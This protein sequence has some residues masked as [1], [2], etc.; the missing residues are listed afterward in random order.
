MVDRYRNYR[1]QKR[2]QPQRQKNR[3][4][5][6][7]VIILA[8]L[9]LGG[10]TVWGRLQHKPQ[11]TDS[12]SSQPEPKPIVNAEPIPATTW[13]ELNQR[14]SALIAAHAALDISVA[15]IDI[16]SNTKAS[17]GI[18]DNFAGASTTKI[19][20]AAAYLH[21]VETAQRSLDEQLDNAA[22]RTHLRRMINRSDNNSWATL[23]RAVGSSQLES[24]AH[25]QGITSYKFNQNLITANDE[26]LL[27]AKLYRGEILNQAH[28][29]L[30][31]SFMQNTNNEDMIPVVAP[32]E[33]ALYHKYGQLE[34]R[35]HDAA[36]VDYQNHP[37]VLVIYTKGGASDGSNYA[38]RIQL[39]QELARNVFE[40]IYQE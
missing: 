22:G 36:I 4:S 17:Y 28:K 5:I 26:A 34:D 7:V 8:I 27:L 23:N 12:T 18:Q 13:N 33:A 40:V 15:V 2:S 14:I 38:G 9:L 19:L 32:K 21:E 10:R 16:N 37:I 31:L 35:L 24:Y 11:S 29:E 6:Y 20:T 1:P 39:V 3:R 25:S 30:L